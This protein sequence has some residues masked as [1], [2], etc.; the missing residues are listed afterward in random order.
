MMKPIPGFEKYLADESGKVINSETGRVLKHSLSDKGYYHVSLWDGEKPHF[1]T[2]HRIVATLFIPNPNNYPIINHIDGN[3]KNN[4]VDNLEWCTQLHNVTHAA[5]TLR[6][7][8]QYEDANK[9]R[10]KPVFGI[11]PDGSQTEVFESVGAASRAYNL[12]RVNIFKAIKN[13]YKCGGITW[14]Y[15]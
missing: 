3:T 4:S 12:N 5:L 2:V 10:Q 8:H 1:L 6:T 13:H 7:M 11:L 15:V 9:K 14:H